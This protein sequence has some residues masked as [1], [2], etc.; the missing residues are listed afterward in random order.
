[1][2]YLYLKHRSGGLKATVVCIKGTVLYILPIKNMSDVCHILLIKQGGQLYFM[3][4]HASGQTI[5]SVVFLLGIYLQSLNISADKYM[6][7]VRVG[8]RAGNSYGPECFS[9]E[10]SQWPFHVLINADMPYLHAHSP[11]DTCPSTTHLPPFSMS[12]HQLLSSCEILDVSPIAT[13]CPA[14]YKAW[15]RPVTICSPSPCLPKPQR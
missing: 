11:Q 8:L 7:P 1:M 3:L 9:S 13:L 10:Q 14:S 15:R 12:C 5:A 2:C 6:V 4:G